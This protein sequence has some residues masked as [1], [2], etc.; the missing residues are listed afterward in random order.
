MALSL[1]CRR[2]A[3][4]NLPQDKLGLRDSVG[5]AGFPRWTWPVAHFCEF[6]SGEDS[7]GKENG[8]LPFLTEG[9]DSEKAD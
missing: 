7:C 6:S 4:L 3:L 9:R 8:V 5:Y 2:P 1:V